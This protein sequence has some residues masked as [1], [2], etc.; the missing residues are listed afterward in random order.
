M[1]YVRGEG[2]RLCKDLPSLVFS[3]CLHMVTGFN[4]YT[5]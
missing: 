3:P 1:L 2:E 4:A 5:P